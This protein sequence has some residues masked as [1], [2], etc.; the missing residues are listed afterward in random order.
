MVCVFVWFA[1]TV[2]T[3][4]FSE[5]STRESTGQNSTSL[6]LQNHR[7]LNSWENA[8]STTYLT[9]TLQENGSGTAPVS[10]AIIF[11]IKKSP[12]SSQD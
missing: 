4:K 2:S 1:Q 9:T 7:N 6:E 11:Y 12:T 10:L 8:S 3:F 5:T